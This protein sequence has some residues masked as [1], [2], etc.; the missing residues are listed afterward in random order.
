MIVMH[1]LEKS[2][3]VTILKLSHANP[4]LKLICV[5][6]P[7]ILEFLFIECYSRKSSTKLLRMTATTTTMSSFAQVIILKVLVQEL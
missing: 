6:S 4:A 5:F 7:A 2:E 1:T 3:I